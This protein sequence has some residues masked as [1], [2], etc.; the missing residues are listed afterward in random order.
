MSLL[1]CVH[2]H[3]HM[4]M[5]HLINVFAGQLHEGDVVGEG[6]HLGLDVERLGEEGV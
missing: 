1:A 5:M 2:S 6:V 4:V 3:I